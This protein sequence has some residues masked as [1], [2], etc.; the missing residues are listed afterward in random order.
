MST[1]SLLHGLRI[2]QHLVTEAASYG[3][4]FSTVTYT[5][6]GLV[7]HLDK[8]E[9]GVAFAS[10]LLDILGLDATNIRDFP[11]SAHGGAF[12]STEFVYRGVS[13]DMLG[14]LPAEAAVSA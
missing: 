9:D 5:G 14:S 10:H 8:T 3:V 4:T 6:G 1:T 11:D 7:V 13:V 12:R 2:A